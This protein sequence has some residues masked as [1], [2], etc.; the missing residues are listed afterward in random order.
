MPELVAVLGDLAAVEGGLLEVTGYS[1][2]DL[3]DLLR[4]VDGA[5]GG[6]DPYAEWV[7][8][9]DY[10]QNNRLSPY[11]VMV[12]FA[13]TEDADDFFATIERPRAASMWWPQHDGLP[14]SDNANVVVGEEV[15]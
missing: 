15:M 10:E 2:D 14:S 1:D 11:R 13:T 5:G 8:M 4:Q 9:P 12:H 7:G 3:I 6:H